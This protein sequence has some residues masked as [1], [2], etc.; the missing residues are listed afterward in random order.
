MHGRRSHNLDL[1]PLNPDLERTLGRTC[2][3]PVERETIEMGDNL[4]N[5][6][7]QENVEQSRFENQE[8]KAQN[9]EQVRAW[10]MDFDHYI[11]LGFFCTCCD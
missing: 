11:T 5:A 9:D 4:R 6:N 10:N 7:Q 2:K 8:M 1:I 3:A